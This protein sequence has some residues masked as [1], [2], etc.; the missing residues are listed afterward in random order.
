MKLD[1]DLFQTEDCLE[2]I[3]TRNMPVT[4]GPLFH[5]CYYKEGEEFNSIEKNL[6]SLFDFPYNIDELEFEDLA[7][8][9][10]KVRG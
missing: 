8:Y 2:N 10:D 5:M 1:K 6:E 3:F 9:D 4:S 7:F